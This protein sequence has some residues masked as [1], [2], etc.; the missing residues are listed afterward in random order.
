MAFN[1]YI[2]YDSNTI[3]LDVFNPIYLPDQEL[4]GKIPKDLLRISFTIPWNH[5]LIIIDGLNG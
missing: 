2:P 4:P 5:L 3:D 1:E